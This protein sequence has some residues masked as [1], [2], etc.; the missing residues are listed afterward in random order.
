MYALCN[1]IPCVLKPIIETWFLSPS[2]YHFLPPVTTAFPLPIFLSLSVFNFKP[3]PY[4]LW[5]PPSLFPFFLLFSLR[6]NV[7]RFSFTTPHCFAFCH[8]REKW[9][10]ELLSLILYITNIL[11]VAR[12][13]FRF[14]T[15]CRCMAMFFITYFGTW[16][17]FPIGRF[18][19][20]M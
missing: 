17:T 19:Y 13:Y 12:F 16:I 8:S 9:K 11:Y 14:L 10:I 18:W 3:F 2:F 1:F 4:L 15:W 7:L 5:L 20:R 6:F